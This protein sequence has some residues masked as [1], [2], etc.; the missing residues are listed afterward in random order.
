MVEGKGIE[1]LILFGLIYLV[2]ALLVHPKPRHDNMGWVRGIIDNPF[3]WSDDVNRFL[4]FFEAIL[5]PGK[6]MI[7]F[8]RIIFFYFSPR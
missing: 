3:R 5:L 8:F 7:L 2:L 6:L 1:A 4:F